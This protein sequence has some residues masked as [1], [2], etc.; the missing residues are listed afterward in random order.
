MVVRCRDLIDRQVTQMARL[1]DDL[2]DVARLSGGKLALQRARVLL[3][4]VLDAAIETSL[5]LIEQRRQRLTLHRAE[6]PIALDA[7]AARLT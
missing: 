5:P 1:L 2:L 7:D 3:D 4:T 6:A